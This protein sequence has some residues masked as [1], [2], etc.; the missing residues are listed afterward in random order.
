MKNKIRFFI[1]CIFKMSTV[2]KR[3]KMEK[4]PFETKFLSFSFLPNVID[5]IFLVIGHETVQFLYVFREFC[6]TYYSRNHIIKSGWKTSFLHL[7]MYVCYNMLQTL[8]YQF[9]L[10]KSS[11]IFDD[12]ASSVSCLVQEY[13]LWMLVMKYRRNYVFFPSKLSMEWKYW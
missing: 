12:S 11:E 9:C 3:K 6:G 1:D 10:S 4:I 7:I 8:K 5:N 2:F 13:I